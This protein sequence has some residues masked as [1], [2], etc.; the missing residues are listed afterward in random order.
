MQIQLRQREE[1][2]GPAAD[3][4]LLG[5]W[6]GEVFGAAEYW[7][8]R[9]ASV[10]L[11]LSRQS[12]LRPL[13]LS[14]FIVSLAAGFLGARVFAQTSDARARM[15]AL[16]LNAIENGALLFRSEHESWPSR[17]EEL[18]PRHLKNLHAGSVGSRLR[19]VSGRRRN[20]HRFRRA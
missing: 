7:L 14:T 17:L 2:R 10:G 16:D 18:V 5:L 15:A 3:G 9:A 20:G 4:L 1:M 6:I 8:L 13:F 11:R 12:F 19:A